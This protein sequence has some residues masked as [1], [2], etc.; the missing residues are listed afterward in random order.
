VA[1]VIKR[2]TSDI[3]SNQLKDPRLGFITVTGVE[4]ADDLRYAKIFISIYGE[5]EKQKQ[6]LQGI[7]SA[8]GYIRRELGHR[9]RLKFTPEIDFRIDESIAYGDRIDRL[10]NQ[11][12][13]E[14]H[15]GD[16]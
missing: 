16:V 13:K 1:E 4:L 9:L 3:I 6:S 7:E 10:L 12:S 15:D 2:E 14:R 8:K 11:L 5:P